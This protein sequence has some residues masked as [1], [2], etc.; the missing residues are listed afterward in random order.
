MQAAALPKKGEAKDWADV[1]ET[2]QGSVFLLLK[3][4]E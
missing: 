2:V 4:R 3:L 1:T